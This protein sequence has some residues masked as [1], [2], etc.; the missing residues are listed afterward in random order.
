MK[1][2]QAFSFMFK[3]PE[4]IK[5]VLL[6]GLI[7]LIPLVGGFYLVGWMIEIVRRVIQEQP[8]ALPGIEFGKFIGQ[9]F[10]AMIISLVYNIPTSLFAAPIG[11]VWAVAMTGDESLQT[12]AMVLTVCCGLLLLV[13]G[14]LSLLLVPAAWG[15]FAAKGTLGAGLRFGEVFA[16]LKAAP[17]AYLMAFLGI[18]VGNLIAPLGSILCGVGYFFTQPYASGLVAHLYG[19]AYKQATFNQRMK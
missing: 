4:W 3:D 16:L 6:T 12:V 19:Q 11:A 18:I 15:N 13:Y 5:K 8:D 7:L 10:K 9:G 17:G 14:I 1:F 2:G